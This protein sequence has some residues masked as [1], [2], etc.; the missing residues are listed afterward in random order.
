MIIAFVI[1]TCVAF[2]FLGIAIYCR[3]C[4]NPVGF[5]TFQEAPVIKDIQGYNKAV[6]KLWMLYSIVFFIYGIPFL[7][8]KQNSPF[9]I[10]LIF[11]VIFGSIA[12]LLAYSKIEEK[13]RDLL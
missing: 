4:K 1:W 5:Y 10:F 9:F 13:Y 12:L 3:T 11:P 2:L 6:S 8:L 7:F